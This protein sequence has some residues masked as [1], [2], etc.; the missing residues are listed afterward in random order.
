MDFQKITETD[1]S[2]RHLENMGTEELLQIINNEDRKVPEVISGIIPSIS[3]L[4]NNIADKKY[5]TLRT[6]EYPGPGIIPSN[7]RSFYLGITARF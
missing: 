6:D 7:G 1:S 4:V 2:Y 5:F 3:L